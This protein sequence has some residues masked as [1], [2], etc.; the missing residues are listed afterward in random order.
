M[1]GW[2]CLFDSWLK[3]DGFIFRFSDPGSLPGSGGGGNSIGGLMKGWLKCNGFVF[4][5]D[6]RG[7]PR[8]PLV[9]LVTGS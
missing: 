7:L 3:T 6:P 4:L 2:G 8:G 9:L 5:V 1:N